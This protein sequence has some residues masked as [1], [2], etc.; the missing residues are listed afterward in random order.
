MFRRK[1]VDAGPEINPETGLPV[2]PNGYFFEV[3]KNSKITGEQWDLRVVRQSDNVVV[4]SVIL[5]YRVASLSP[6]VIFD[7]ATDMLFY[8]RAEIRK[9]K[10][11]VENTKYIGQFPPNSIG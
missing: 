5:G 3:K 1:K 4:H 8:A 11:D 2:L 10:L 7:T 9:L 6:G